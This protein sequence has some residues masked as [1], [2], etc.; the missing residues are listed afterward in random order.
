[1][2]IHPGKDETQSEWMSR[3]VPEMM[4][5]GKRP[6]EQAVAACLQMWRDKDKDSGEYVTRAWATLELKRA[7]DERMEIRGT[8]STPQTDR[9][10]D[11][12]EPLGLEFQNP[13][14]LLWHH[15]HRA[16]IGLAT[17]DKPSKDGV[18]FTARL[19]RIDA[20]GPLKDRIDEAWQ[21]IKA[22]L[23]KGVS[24][25]FK[26]LERSF[27]KDSDGIRFIRSD[28][29]ELSLVTIPANSQATISTIKN[30]DAASELAPELKT[31]ARKL[32]GAAGREATIRKVKIMPVTIAEQIS[33]YEAR[34]TTA[35]EAMKALMTKATD[36][37]RT[38]SE[39]ETTEYDGYDAE[40]Q[41]INETLTR[42][43]RLETLQRN[44][45]IQVN[46][47]GIDEAT[48]SRNGRAPAATYPHVV[49]LNQK[50]PP[51]T[52]FIRYCIALG[53]G[54]GFRQHALEYARR[55]TDW[56]HTTP[57]ILKLFEDDASYYMR[58]AQPAGTTYDSAWA[59]AL[60][61]AQNA[62][63]EFAEFLRPLTII[64]RIPGLR[65]VPFNVRIPRATGGTSAN[66]VGENAPK[67]VTAMSFD[68]ITMTWAKAAA[69]VVI[70]E[71]L[72]RFSNPAAEG[73]IR[74]DLSDSIIQFLDRQFV[75]QSVAAVTGVSPASITN[76]ITP[77][78][79]TGTNMA[80]FR[81]DMKTLFNSLLDDNQR[82]STG[83]FI[84][85]QQQALAL[86][87]AQNSL[88]QTIYPTINPEQGG[89]LL[90]YPVI[91]SENIPAT[92]GSPTDGYPLIFAVAN[93]ILL[94]DDG[95]TLVDASREAS[96]QM[97][98]A[99]D[100]P[101]TASSN[102]ISLWQNNQVGIRCERWMTWARRRATAVAWIQNAKYA[103]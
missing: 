54:Q 96:V 40:A 51:A 41:N 2:P 45:A 57:D 100:S 21:S 9:M 11:V 94:A 68:S 59:G 37:G 6:Q 95:T 22:G 62:T 99:P 23:V 44:E 69:I 101:P 90:G 67:P 14:P 30:F 79:A 25:G 47:N 19:A 85:T 78:T 89:T 72:A 18:T 61:Y 73:I 58:A 98:T 88:G 1:M 76:G 31:D 53:A 39:A 81:T 52:M 3:C 16:P 12:V 91:A 60:V 33:A 34:R 70:T 26:A 15:D 84:M 93:E 28:V 87:L 83:V 63:A 38:L 42:L 64:G 48:A 82:L 92:G 77:I 20:P 43:K 80:A 46:G 4:G 36:E 86:S 7:D 27:L 102:M 66:W 49:M 5:D 8:A 10:G 13:L 50:L 29:I 74:Q 65:R 24:I 75:D 71:E 17:L 97:D 35:T 103:E 55:R 32:P 56:L